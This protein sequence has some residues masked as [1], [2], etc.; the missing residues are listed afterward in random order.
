[1]QV[2]EKPVPGI[3]HHRTLAGTA[4]TRSTLPGASL[5]C[6]LLEPAILI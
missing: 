1:M 6:C 3:P 4:A 5:P 2:H